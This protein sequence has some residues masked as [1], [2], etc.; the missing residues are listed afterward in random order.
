MPASLP[1]IAV[2]T[3]IMS[4]G[5]QISSQ[6][7][8]YD[9]RPLPILPASFFM[10]Y[11]TLFTRHYVQNYNQQ[12]FCTCWLEITLT[13]LISSLSIPRLSFQSDVM[14][15]TGWIHWPRWPPWLTEQAL[16]GTMCQS[17]GRDE[18]RPLFMTQKQHQMLQLANKMPAIY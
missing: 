13:R 14:T 8:C 6:T 17:A 10:I 11:R 9:F 16:P 12:Q 18:Y 1:A 2:F 3:V 4:D 5:R 7:L 15:S